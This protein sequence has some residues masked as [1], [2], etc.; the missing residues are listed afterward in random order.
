MCKAYSAVMAKVLPMKAVGIMLME[1]EISLAGLRL[2]SD[3]CRATRLTSVCI[4]FRVLDYHGKGL[5]SETKTM[6]GRNQ[7]CARFLFAAVLR[8]H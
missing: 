7:V 2:A 6:N 1:G 8:R 3:K 4:K 5:S